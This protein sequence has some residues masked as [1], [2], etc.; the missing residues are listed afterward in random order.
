MEI[1]SMYRP[2]RPP[3]KS[4]HS[5]NINK[6]FKTAYWGNKKVHKLKISVRK[7]IIIYYKYIWPCKYTK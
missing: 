1:V 6:A 4:S 5:G 2:Y 7:G 3:I